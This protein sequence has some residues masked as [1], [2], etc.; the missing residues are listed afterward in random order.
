MPARA[1]WTLK[2]YTMCM[3]CI[4]HAPFKRGRRLQLDCTIPRL[5]RG[6]WYNNMRS[7]SDSAIITICPNNER[8][9]QPIVILQY[10]QQVYSMQLRLM[11]RTG[12]RRVMALSLIHI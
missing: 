4:V 7:R 9:T 5:V 11:A 12:T 8:Q 10:V 2:A 3:V 6:T 1:K